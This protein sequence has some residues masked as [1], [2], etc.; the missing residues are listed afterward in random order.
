MTFGRPMRISQETAARAPFPPVVDDEYLAESAVQPD[1]QP[2]KL[3]FFIAYCKL[4]EILADILSN[5][6]AP[7]ANW[8]GT[9]GPTHFST[10]SRT[11]NIDKLLRIDRGMNEWY[12]GLEPYLQLSS[13]HGDGEDAFTFKRQAFI[14]YAR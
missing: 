12:N 14:L 8:D 4:H 3:N 9:S 7:S 1:G 2:S 5:F 10:R 6:Y 13:S 11:R